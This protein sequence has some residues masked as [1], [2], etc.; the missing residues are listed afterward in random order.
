MAQLPLIKSQYMDL[1]LIQS[2]WKSQLDPILAN[3]LTQGNLIS[4]IA[5]KSGDNVIN[6][7]LGRMM[8]GWLLVDQDK[9]VTIYRSAPLNGQTLTLNASGTVNISLWVF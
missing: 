8:Q 5:L 2:K 9:G 7:L 6:H 4:S 1:E 3:R